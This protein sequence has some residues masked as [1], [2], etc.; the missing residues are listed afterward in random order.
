MPCTV[1]ELLARFR[2]FVEERTEGK[3]SNKVR[4]VVEW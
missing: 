4:I 2:R 1:Q 3:D